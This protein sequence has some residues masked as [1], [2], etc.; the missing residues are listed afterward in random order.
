[1]NFLIGAACFIAGALIGIFLLSLISARR[2]RSMEIEMRKRSIRIDE[3]IKEL[4]IER[5]VNGR[6]ERYDNPFQGGG[7]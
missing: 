7:E 1:M 3:I 6:A 5:R 2:I 4:E